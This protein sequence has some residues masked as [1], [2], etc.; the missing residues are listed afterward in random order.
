M[1][2][3]PLSPYSEAAML[4]WGGI[5]GAHVSTWIGL[6]IIQKLLAYALAILVTM[7]VFWMCRKSDAVEV[8]LKKHARKKPKK[9]T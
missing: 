1:S 4:V 3:R 8:F 5:V 6:N 2:N 9:K 7:A